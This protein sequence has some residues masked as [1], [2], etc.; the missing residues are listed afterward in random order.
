MSQVIPQS[1]DPTIRYLSTTQA[2]DLWSAVY[3][4]DGNFLQALDTIEM[5]ILIPRM[6]RILEDRVSYPRPW[7]LVDLGCGTGRNTAAL[8]EV[9]DAAS[10]VG[11]DLSPGMLEVARDRLQRFHANG[12]LELKVYDMLQEPS[13]PECAVGADA[14]VS[15]LVIEHIPADVFFATVAKILKPGGIL[16]LTNMHSD[17]G[18]ISQA[19]FI[20]PQTGEKIR[21]TSYSHTLAEVEAAASEKGFEVLGQIEER[22]VDESMVAGLGQRSEKWVGVTVWFGGIL[23]KSR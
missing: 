9:E 15:T 16:V 5:K 13:P 7:T 11:L 6:L 18:Q 8:L 4:T 21:P 12:K 19:G 20:D 22:R 14:V 10:V 23:R 1:S 17:M 3:D 2:Y